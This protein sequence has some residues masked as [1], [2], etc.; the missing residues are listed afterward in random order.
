[1]RVR[2]AGHAGTLAIPIVVGTKA[3]GDN[4]F[5]MTLPLGG[6]TYDAA[7]GPRPAGGR[8]PHPDGGPGAVDGVGRRRRAGGR[9]GDGTRRTRI[10]AYRAAAGA[11]APPSLLE[12]WRWTLRLW[13]PDDHL[14]LARTMYLGWQ[15]QLALTPGLA[16]RGSGQKRP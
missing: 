11:N 13:T 7:A 10:L 2:R 14:K 16:Q 8:L 9:R 6:V 1:M 15:A 12:N 5:P 3:L 4:S